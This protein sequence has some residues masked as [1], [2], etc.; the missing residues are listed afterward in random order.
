[1]M[2]FLNQKKFAQAPQWKSSLSLSDGT[3]EKKK[4]SRK[5]FVKLP[6]SIDSCIWKIR[7]WKLQGYSLENLQK[8]KDKNSYTQD[9]FIS[10]ILREATNKHRLYCRIGSKEF[11]P[12]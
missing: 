9:I 6:S 12:A 4:P 3:C 8:T 1:M 10:K 11:R 5:L 2:A 7:F